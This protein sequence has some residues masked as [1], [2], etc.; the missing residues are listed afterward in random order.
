MQA[1]LIM[2]LDDA[3][4]MPVLAVRVTGRSA[5]GAREIMGRAGYGDGQGY[6]WMHPLS[7]SEMR[8]D[9]RAWGNR[10]RVAA[11]LVL[12]AH[13]SKFGHNGDVLDVRQYPAQLNE[14]LRMFGGGERAAVFGGAQ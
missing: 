9:P 10:T 11:H 1:K 14:A 7:T 2:V 5:S 13:W 6:V 8:S 3:T 4:E 12:D